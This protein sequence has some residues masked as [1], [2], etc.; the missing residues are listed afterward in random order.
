MSSSIFLLSIGTPF[1][2]DQFASSKTWFDTKVP[3]T[4]YQNI[5]FDTF[6]V[7]LDSLFVCE[8]RYDGRDRDHSGV[9][10]RLGCTLFE[11][12]FQ[13]YDSRHAVDDDDDLDDLE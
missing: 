12:I 8:L 13:W 9:T 2:K 11:F 4:K 3:F 5:S 1:V 10:I 7:C 6:G